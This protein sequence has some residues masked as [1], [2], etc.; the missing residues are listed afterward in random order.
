MVV[1]NGPTQWGPTRGLLRR[2][3]HGHGQGLVSISGTAI[4]RMIGSNPTVSSQ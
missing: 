1:E 3:A 2:V 4:T